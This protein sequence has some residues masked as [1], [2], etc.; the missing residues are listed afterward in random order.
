M[1]GHSVQ[2]RLVSRRFSWHNGM[3]TCKSTVW[4]AD[5]AWSE[6]N[7]MTRECGQLNSS[8][9]TRASLVQFDWPAGVVCEPFDWHVGVV[10]SVWLNC[11]FVNMVR[12]QFHW[13]GHRKVNNTK[14]Q[15]TEMDNVTVNKWPCNRF[16]L[17][18]IQTANN[19]Y[20]QIVFG[21]RWRNLS[22]LKTVTT[23]EP[24]SSTDGKD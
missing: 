24:L 10:G 18:V 5:V 16:I 13:Y 21:S 2:V 23:V 19:E 22:R 6:N 3:T 8:T 14:Q 15:E 12:T 9:T 11:G 20:L 7:L 17:K 4:H 1:H